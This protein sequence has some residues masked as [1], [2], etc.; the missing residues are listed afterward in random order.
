MLAGLKGFA[1]VPDF[2]SDHVVLKTL[3][4]LGAGGH[5]GTSVSAALDI[6][7]SGRYPLSLLQT[8]ALPLNSAEHA[9]RITAREVPGEEPVHV[10]LL[11]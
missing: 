4:I 11:P 3:R 2:V 9:L 8:H 6:I 1:P 10:A 5:D 7:A